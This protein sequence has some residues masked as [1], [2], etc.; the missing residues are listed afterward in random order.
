MDAGDAF[1]DKP[2]LMAGKESSSK[3]KAKTIVK[4]YNR[5]GYDVV[6]VG[7]SDF[8][9]GRDFLQELIDSSQA[10]FISANIIDSESKKVVFKPSLI[11]ERGGLKVGVIGLTT[12]LPEKITDLELKDYLITG[13]EEIKLLRNKVEI[14]VV[15]LNAPK[16]EIEKARKAFKS[17]DYI[18]LSRESSRTRPDLP[19]IDGLPLMYSMNIQGKYIARVDINVKDNTKPIY[20]ITSAKLTIESISKRMYNLQKK[21]LNKKL[22]DIYKDNAGILK[23]IKKYRNNLDKSKNI[24]D[25]AVNKSYYTLI[26]LDK[27]VESDSGLLANVDAVLKTCLELENPLIPVL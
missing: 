15:L 17:A 3:L 19:Q 5:I 13:Q 7:Q 21:N 24:I 20:D 18:F 12:S 1:F 16:A 6:N 27:K 4:G 25:S 2:V 8:A 22:D 10:E 9:A 26:A 14:I 11:V 23:L